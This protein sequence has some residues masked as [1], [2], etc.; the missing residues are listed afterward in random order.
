MVISEKVVSE[1]M[2]RTTGEKV[3]S[4]FNVIFILLMC[5]IMLYPYLNQLAV[6]LND[7]MDSMKGGITIFPRVF[8]WEN[9]KAV[10]RND[11][12]SLSATVSVL[13]VV[14]STALSLLVVYSCAF[15]LTRKNLPYR[16]GITLFLMIPAYITA[17]VIPT[18]ILYRYLHLINNFLVYVLPSAFVFY[19]MVIIRSFL[20]DIPES[21]E[22]SAQIDGA[23]EICI[24]FKIIMPLSL[25]VIAT[26]A[27]WGAVAAWNDWTTTLMYVTNSELY[28]LQYLMMRIIKE[29]ETAQQMALQSSMNKGSVAN[30][31]Q[32][33]SESVKSATLIVTTIPII[34]VYPFLQKYFI[35]GVTIGAVKG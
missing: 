2:K 18:Y 7:G 22:E 5:I 14:C 33:T 20:Q 34:L 16:R 3:F 32:P 28:P 10:L 12:F 27:L 25:P 9:Y 29:S 4:I 26:V 30:L 21:I 31:S 1:F 23:N 17:G 24:M 8:T 35:K 15:G 13:R 6:S 19:N 11:Y